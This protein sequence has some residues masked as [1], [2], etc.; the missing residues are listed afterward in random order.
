MDS[1][2]Y[3]RIFTTYIYSSAE[4]LRF[5]DNFFFEQDNDPNILLKN[6]RIFLWKQY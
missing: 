6:S 2:E 3:K 5:N 1:I 4:K